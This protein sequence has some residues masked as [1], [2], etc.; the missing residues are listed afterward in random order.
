MQVIQKSLRPA[1][2]FPPALPPRPSN[3]AWT[4]LLRASAELPFLLQSAR[5]WAAFP[6]WSLTPAGSAPL[7]SARP[8]TRGLCPG[9]RRKQVSV[10]SL[11]REEEIRQRPRVPSRLIWKKPS[12]R[13]RQRVFTGNTDRHA[14]LLEGGETFFSK[15]W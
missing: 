15:E 12:A 3:R 1:S 9:A 7:P 4:A 6:V 2:L 13:P 11:I 14:E 5:S 10:C 8:S